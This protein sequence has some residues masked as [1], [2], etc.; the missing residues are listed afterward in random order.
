LTGH[1]LLPDIARDQDGIRPDDIG[2]PDRT[3]G[4]NAADGRRFRCATG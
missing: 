2:D 4:G 1:R 3:I